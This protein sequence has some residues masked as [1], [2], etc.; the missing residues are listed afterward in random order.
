MQKTSY[1]F[2]NPDNGRFLRVYSTERE[3]DCITPYREFTFDE[4]EPIYETDE[5]AA[6]L[7]IMSGR[8]N[9]QCL[10]REARSEWTPRVTEWFKNRLIRRK[11]QFEDYVPV[12]FIRDLQPVVDGGDLLAVS[13]S[14]RLVRF[15]DPAD[16]ESIRLD[17]IENRHPAPNGAVSP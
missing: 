17:E 12:A 1:A 5:A 2:L 10:S 14:V 8:R 9:G 6:L 3:E 4:D 13:M 15:D 11:E 7:D 16:P